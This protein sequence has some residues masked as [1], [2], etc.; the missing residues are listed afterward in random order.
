MKPGDDCYDK[1]PEV[2]FPWGP[3]HRANGHHS[4]RSE[5]KYLPFLS[6]SQGIMGEEGHMMMMMMMMNERMKEVKNGASE[7]R[8]R[9]VETQSDKKLDTE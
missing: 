9:K 5:G 3:R 6:G 2:S 7:R 1:T 4:N 8:G